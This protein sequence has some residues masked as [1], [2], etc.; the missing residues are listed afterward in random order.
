M[1][2]PKIVLAVNS[3]ITNDPCALC[4]A[5][6]DPCGL[7][8]TLES[9]KPGRVLVCDGCAE[10][11]APGL[12]KARETALQYAR[13]EQEQMTENSPPPAVV[14][15]NERLRQLATHLLAAVRLLKPDIAEPP[16]RP[17]PF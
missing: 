9:K 12:V 11:D 6:C 4:G 15:D 5:R 13:W 3:C 14:Q 10:K 2:D 16:E 1:Q 17:S 8:Y 7:D